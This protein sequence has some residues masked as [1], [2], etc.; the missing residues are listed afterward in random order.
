MESDVSDDEL[1]FNN[2][3]EWDVALD[4]YGSGD[5]VGQIQMMKMNMFRLLLAGM[6]QILVGLNSLMMGG[7]LCSGL[8]N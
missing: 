2:E 8:D 1:N 6:R 7:V 5:E 3:D 4:D